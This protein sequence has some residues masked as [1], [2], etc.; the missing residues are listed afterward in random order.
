MLTLSPEVW[1]SKLWAIKFSSESFRSKKVPSVP[2]DSEKTGI[3]T[4]THWEYTMKR[5]WLR[6]NAALFLRPLFLSLSLPFH[7]AQK[8]HCSS[9]EW[10]R[11]MELKLC[12]DHLCGRGGFLHQ[13]RAQ[14][15]WEQSH[16]KRGGGGKNSKCHKKQNS[17][18]KNR[19]N[20]ER[21][22]ESK[23]TWTW[24]E[25]EINCTFMKLTTICSWNSCF[26]V[27]ATVGGI[28]VSLHIYNPLCVWMSVWVHVQKDVYLYKV[29]CCSDAEQYYYYYDAFILHKGPFSKT[30]MT[31]FQND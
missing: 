20:K 5:T 6:H 24:L 16:T 31:S 18:K 8:I 12:Y 10:V 4:N 29:F 25:F 3:F 7:D 2:T 28:N 22:V 1:K 11:G 30:A 9:A 15:R 27:R 19:N 17:A 26:L 13:E 14:T 23:I 21:D